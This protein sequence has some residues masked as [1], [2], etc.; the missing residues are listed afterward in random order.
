[1]KPPPP[2]GRK[3]AGI[4][5]IALLIVIWAALVASLSNFVGQWP[6]LLQALFYLVAGL[7][8]IAPLRPLIRWIETGRQRG[9]TSSQD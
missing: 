1:M 3:L 2:S 6:I 5:I 4:L 7:A 9:G 8:W